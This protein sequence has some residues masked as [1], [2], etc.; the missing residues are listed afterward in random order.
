MKG[1]KV[2]MVNIV[3]NAMLNKIVAVKNSSLKT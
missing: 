1:L 3:N 2:V